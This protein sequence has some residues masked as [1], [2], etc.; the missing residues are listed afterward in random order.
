MYHAEA[1]VR[2]E[3]TDEHKQQA[4]STSFREGMTK[5]LAFIVT[6]IT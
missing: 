5:T 4:D 1:V 2:N 3:Q 6:H